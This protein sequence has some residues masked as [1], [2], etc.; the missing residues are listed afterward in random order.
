MATALVIEEDRGTYIR[1]PHHP[2]NGYYAGDFGST[3]TPLPQLARSQF[4]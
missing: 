2:H 1:S 4:S 3:T